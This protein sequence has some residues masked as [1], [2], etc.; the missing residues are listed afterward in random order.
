MNSSA[1]RNRIFGLVLGISVAAVLIVGLTAPR[2]AAN[3]RHGA[4]IQAQSAI[5][6]ADG[7]ESNGGKGGK[8]SKIANVS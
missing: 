4:T 7:S 2:T 6:V 5:Q 8:G 3:N 1:I